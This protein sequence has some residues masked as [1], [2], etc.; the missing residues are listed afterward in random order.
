MPLR[1]ILFVITKAE[2][3][4]AQKYVRDLAHA[5]QRDGFDVT[6]AS[7][8]NSHL[9]EEM[10]DAEIP[11]REIKS[12]RREISFF[13]DIKLFWELFW[14]IRKEKPDI[15]HLNSSK[16]GAVGAVA[17]KLAHVPYIIFTA[18]GWVFNEQRPKWQKSVFTLITKIAARF[19]D[20]IICV[21][22]YD[23]KRAGELNIAPEEK[24]VTI[25]NG[26]DVSALKPLSRK[27]ARVRLTLGE[28]DFVVGTVA[29]FYKNKSL[30][31]LVFAAI[32]AHS[33]PVK[34][35]IIGEGPEKEK[36]EDL[37]AKYKLED[38]FILTGAIQNAASYLKAFDVFALPSKKEGFPYA[39]LEAMAAKLPCVASAVGGV[40]EILHDGKNGILISHM[41]PGKLW[42]AVAGLSKNK[43]RAQELGA[44]AAET[45]ALKFSLESSI[46]K[47]LGLYRQAPIDNAASKE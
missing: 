5:A 6:V 31:T 32:S 15:L 44:S 19:Q 28:K 29:N 38:R 27:E 9:W 13:G 24:L 18:H 37:I 40:P 12:V 42:D 43:K 11:F 8:A 26:V 20:I 10:H 45:I 16:V 33:S 46:Q 7:E 47:T 30:D 36:I 17:G 21:S 1:K 14:L 23:K 34:F 35:V 39:L 41:T 25:Y 3:G 22:E 2:I 4:G